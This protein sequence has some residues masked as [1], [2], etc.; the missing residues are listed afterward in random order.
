MSALQF[1]LGSFIHL[2]RTGYWR[3]RVKERSE[4]WCCIMPSFI[5]PAGN[6]DYRSLF[7]LKV[8]MCSVGCAFLFLLTLAKIKSSMSPF[9]SICRFP[10]L[11]SIRKHYEFSLSLWPFGFYSF[12]F[13][14]YLK[15]QF[16]HSSFFLLLL[17][18]P[19]YSVVSLY[20]IHRYSTFFPSVL[21][22]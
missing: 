15:S 18:P 7:L 2:E 17:G 6:T 12:Q 3:M 5:L 8:R 13:L 19:F 11:N 21:Y 14:I 4:K 10:L 20:P 22:T 16:R 9:S 1:L